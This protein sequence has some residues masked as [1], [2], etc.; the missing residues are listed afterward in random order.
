MKLYKRQYYLKKIREFYQDKELIK[1]LTGIRGSGKTCMMEMIINELRWRGNA[2]VNLIHI[3]LDTK[4]FRNI[5]NIEK[6]RIAIKEKMVPSKD[7]TIYLF[8][9]EI[10]MID[11]FET[12]IETLYNEGRYSIFLS[13]SSSYLLSDTFRQK[14]EDHYKVF[15]IFPLSYAEYEGMKDFMGMK[16]EENPLLEFVRYVH[17]G[18]L[19]RI[20]QCDN[21]QE[22]QKYILGVLEEIFK[23]DIAKMEKIRHVVY[24]KQVQEYIIDTFGESISMT[25]L[26]DYFRNYVRIPVKRETLERYLE[27]LE[28]AKL[29]YRCN[30]FDIK[31]EKELQGDQRYYLT[32]LGFYFA[33]KTDSKIDYSLIMK[34]IIYMYLRSREYN[35]A[36]GRIG[37][38]ECDFVLA[39]FVSADELGSDSGREGARAYRSD[40]SK[41]GTKGN[42][43]VAQAVSKNSITE[44]IR[45]F[46]ASRSAA[47]APAP[48]TA[49]TETVERP[50]D[51]NINVRVDE[52]KNV[53]NGMSSALQKYL[54]SRKQSAAVNGRMGAQERDGMSDAEEKTRTFAG[55]E[56]VEEP[57]SEFKAEMRPEKET[58]EMDD[59][60][61]EQ[62][63]GLDED[64]DEDM[65]DDEREEEPEFVLTNFRYIKFAITTADP[66]REQVEYAALDSIRDNYPKFMLTLDSKIQEHNDIV[67]LNAIEA[68]KEEKEF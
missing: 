34:N 43:V 29:V 3:D 32:D 28:K 60:L 63:V 41:S 14:F 62:A 51:I 13:A 48:K 54:E 35:I 61:F 15:E 59:E 6:L 18:G 10:Q 19:P 66:Y 52:E 27:L 31:T 39:D 21:A 16:K 40:K 7:G 4:E 65:M 9:D 30:R 20:L 53:S 25:R 55:V 37:K 64:Y 46:K 8:I 47:A 67:H 56:T 12:L 1:V 26:T 23:K 57:V 24:F 42:K 68:L 38:R 50:Q 58:I 36:T 49:A 44:R 11:D 2:A 22:K 33:K 17:D 5:K 45:E